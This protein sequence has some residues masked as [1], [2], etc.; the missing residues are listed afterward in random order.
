MSVVVGVAFKSLAD[1]LAPATQAPPA[2]AAR[3]AAR[4]RRAQPSP[5]KPVEEEEEVQQQMYTLVWRADAPWEQQ[6]PAA[7]GTDMLALT[8]GGS[9]AAAA[10]RAL[11]VLQAPQS[12]SRL[13][14]RTAGAHATAAPS[15]A[16]V[17]TGAAGAMPWAMLR[18][19]ALECP[20]AE[21]SALD[22]GGVQ[23]SI[24]FVLGAA[25]AACMTP[26]ESKQQNLY[27]CSLAGQVLVSARLARSAALPAQGQQ[28]LQVQQL[29]DPQGT[30]I[31]TGGTGFVGIQVGGGEL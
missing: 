16:P 8:A 10:L 27:G 24:G 25:A 23:Q 4:Q 26:A 17:H 28:Q 15:P 1:L 30:F 2:G 29:L 6:H 11:A 13:H 14:L 19:A 9:S 18:C 20:G 12:S 7:G 5:K 22:Q 21:L 3:R 31:I